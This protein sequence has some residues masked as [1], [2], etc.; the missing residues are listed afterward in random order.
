MLGTFNFEFP[1]NRHWQGNGVFMLLGQ[2]FTRITPVSCSK[3][4]TFNPDKTK[5]PKLS[6]GQQ[7]YE[8]CFLVNKITKKKIGEREVEIPTSELAKL[9][10]L[11]NLEDKIGQS[12]LLE[13][14]TFEV[15]PKGAKQTFYRI[16]GIADLS[17][18]AK[19]AA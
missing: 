12:L 19:K 16:K 10:S 14:D 18:Q 2:L 11:I 15:G 13:L 5:S 9:N 1:L 6:N 8:V 17:V 3:A 4:E 7:V